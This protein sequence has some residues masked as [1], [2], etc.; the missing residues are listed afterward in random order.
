MEQTQNTEI[1]FSVKTSIGCILQFPRTAQRDGG[2]WLT[3]HERIFP[4]QKKKPTAEII[5]WY[6]GADS[7]FK[8][9]K[10]LF[11]KSWRC[12]AKP[13]SRTSSRSRDFRP[14]RRRRRRTTAGYLSRKLFFRLE[15]KKSL[16]FPLQYVAE[17]LSLSGRPS[18]S[19]NSLDPKGVSAVY[20]RQMRHAH[21]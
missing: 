7:V 17:V 5:L 3:R 9:N 8:I 19:W 11:V 4:N 6:A 10:N 1:I 13:I 16:F 12:R 14:R 21:L 18:T 20:S 15:K 2:W